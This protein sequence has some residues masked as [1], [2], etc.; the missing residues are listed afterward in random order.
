RRDPRGARGRRY[1]QRGRR[2]RLRTLRHRPR[3]RRRFRTAEAARSPRAGETAERRP[4]RRGPQADEGVRMIRSKPA[5][6]ASLLAAS[7]VGDR[8]ARADDP[9]LQDLL[10]EP[11]ITTASK[12]K[13]KGSTAPAIST[14]LTA[15]DIRNYGIHS[16]DEAVD[17]LSLGAVTSNP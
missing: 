4:A 5:L 10:N 2:S 9:S 7:V 11:I 6:V 1:P 12:S 3:L 14:I 15:E 17:F 13:E 8:R 16:I